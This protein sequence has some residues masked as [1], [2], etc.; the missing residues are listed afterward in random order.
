MQIK[1]R[2]LCLVL[3]LALA[4]S[5]AVLA[6][7]GTKSEIK[8]INTSKTAT[9]ATGASSGNEATTVPAASSGNEATTAAA[10]SSS[11]FD[12]T[13]D[14]NDKKDYK[15]IE[16]EGYKKPYKG[17]SRT[18][19]IDVK[20]YG[21]IKLVLDPKFAPISVQNFLNLINEG[22]YDG[23]TFHRIMEGFMIQGGYPQGTGMGGSDKTIK[24]EFL[25]N[26]V[27]NPMSHKRGVIS[28][29]RSQAPD[30]ASSQ[31]FI[32]HKDSTFLDGNYAAFGMVTEGME[33]VDEIATKAQPTDSNG[34]IP[35]ANQPVIT[36]IKIV[37]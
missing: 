27:E 4:L 7:C 36:S 34:T 37:E 8:G 13:P 14:I 11:D 23:L 17:N 18:V 3:A 22:F 9:S 21:K 6:G 20:D 25:S 19:E 32:V 31:F 26:G 16:L 35:A 24:G 1:K 12:Y 30:S 15:A 5:C 2:I 33:V 28:M 29:A 10:T